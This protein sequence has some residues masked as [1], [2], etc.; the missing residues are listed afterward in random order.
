MIER[1]AASRPVARLL[2]VERLQRLVEDWPAGDWERDEVMQAYRL[3]LLRG[4]S[5]G[6]FLS[7]ASG[8]N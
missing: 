4:L 1:I 5:V 2:D 7:K 6:H 8:A 3:A